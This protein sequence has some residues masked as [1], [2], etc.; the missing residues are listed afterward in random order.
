M[1]LA[2]LSIAIGLLAHPASADFTLFSEGMLTPQSISQAPSGFGVYGGSFLIPDTA[3]GSNDPSL[4]T[5]WAVPAMGGSPTPFATGFSDFVRGGLF[6]PDSW[7]DLAGKY[8]TVG[9]DTNLAE[10]ANNGRMFIYDSDGSR[11]LFATI[12]GAS[13]VQPR[14]APDGFGS[15]G[16]QVITPN[17]HGIIQ[18]FTNRVHAI[19]ADGSTSLF[20]DDLPLIDSIFGA[21]F[22]PA[23]FGEF[24]GMLLLSD[25]L[26]GTILAVDAAGNS[27]L[28]ADIPLGTGQLGLRQLEFAPA[29]FIPG[30]DELLFVSI[31]GS[32]VGGGTLGD[33][34]A[35]DSSGAIVASLRMDLG[36][37]K[38]DPRGLLFLDNGTLLISDASDPVWLAT[39]DAFLIRAVPEPASIV[40]IGSGGVVVLLGLRRRGHNA[41]SQRHA[42]ASSQCP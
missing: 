32:G 7:G 22:A 27:S 18:G 33:V 13:L 3:R 4:H 23:G 10:P 9:S 28:F 11:S 12:P 36:L 29:G 6:L 39:R 31:T 8:A 35:L 24:G 40:L 20:A 17:Q 37:T 41:S 25:A 30:F 2:G 14:I 15:F 19:A 38:F 26:S 42:R 16:G 5:V 1:S 34:I 21:A